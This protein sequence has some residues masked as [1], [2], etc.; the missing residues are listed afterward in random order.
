M[1]LRSFDATP[2]QLGYL[3]QSRA[4]VQALASPFGGFAGLPTLALKALSQALARQD[5][6]GLDMH[7]SLHAPHREFASRV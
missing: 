6:L 7:T 5:S 3:T 1:T 2:S 4:L